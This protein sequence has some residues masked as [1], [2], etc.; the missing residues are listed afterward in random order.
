MVK[1]RTLTSLLLPT[2]VVLVIIVLWFV[3]STT[4]VFPPTL[5]PPPAEVVTGF[6]EELRSGRIF[7]DIVASVFR[8]AV[9]F[10]L[11][12]LLGVPFGLWLGNST[13]ARAAFLPGVNFFR[14]VSP[15]AWI[16]FAILWFGIGD[17]SA[18]F[19]I[20]CPPSSPSCW[21]PWQPWQIFPQFIFVWHA[22]TVCMAASCSHR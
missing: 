21:Q 10:G 8:V 14:A 19:L 12:V 15:L 3:L 4:R 11:A 22:I 18:I 9:G 13:L 2:L 6:A 20:L 16:G 7:D 17:K 1:E 5:V